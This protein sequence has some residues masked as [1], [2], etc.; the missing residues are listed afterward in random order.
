MKMKQWLVRLDTQYI[1]DLS[2]PGNKGR[3]TRLKNIR[4]IRSDFQDAIT[5]KR[6]AQAADRPQKEN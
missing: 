5:K 4:A 3:A 6:Q 1:V 2:C